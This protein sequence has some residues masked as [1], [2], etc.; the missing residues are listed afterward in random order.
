MKKIIFIANNNIGNGFSGGDR[1][2]V[3]FL[4]NWQCNAELSLFGSEEAVRISLDRG[5]EKI[6]II[7]TAQRNQAKNIFSL[8]V[9][10]FH[11]IKRT[12][13]GIEALKKNKDLIENANYIYSVSDFYPDFLPALYLKLK[14]KKIR[15]IAG[16]YLFAPAPWQKDSP[17]KGKN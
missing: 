8:W 12:K 14:N 5:V 15:W 4:K 11:I 2:F 10:F 9:T 3:E 17:Y 16:Y 13:K 1:I 6:K 7:Q